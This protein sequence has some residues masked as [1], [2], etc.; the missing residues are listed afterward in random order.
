MKKITRFVS[1]G[2]CMAMLLCLFPTNFAKAA[3]AD[4]TAEQW[5]PMEISLTSTV[6]YSNP[7]K[8]VDI[9][10]VFTYEDGTTISIPGFWNGENEWKVRFSPTKIGNWTF[11]ITCTD[12]ANVSLTKTGTLSAVANTGTTDV[13]K[14]GFVRLE[15]GKR[16]FVYDD[17][18]PFYW[19]GDTH[20]Q[21]PNYERLTECNYPGCNCGSQFAHLLKNRLEKGF[22]VYQTYPDSGMSDGGGNK[23]RYSWWTKK[24]L[25]KPESFNENFDVMMSQLAEVGMTVAMGLGVHSSTIGALTEE[26]LLAYTRYVVARYAC[27]NVV[28]ITGQEITIDKS[29]DPEGYETWKKVAALIDQLDGYKHPQG[30]HMYPLLYEDVVDLDAQPWHEWWTLQAGHGGIAGIKDQT[31]YKSYYD[32]PTQKLYMETEA[33]YED[34]YCGGFT[35]YTAS[36]I[37]AW[38]ANQ[39]G[40]YGFTYGDE[41]IWAMRWDTSASG[42]TTYNSEPWYAGMDKPGSYEMT[43]LKK[44][45]QYVGFYNLTPRFN[46]PAYGTFT[47][48]ERSVISTDGNSTYVV[49]FYSATNLTGKLSGLDTTQN[50]SARWYNPRTGKF[51]VIAHQFKAEADG[52]YTIP[53]KPTSSD[54]TLLVTNKDLGAYETELAPVDYAA[55]DAAVQ[56]D[57]ALLEVKSYQNIINSEDHAIELAFDKDAST[58]WE[59]FASRVSN[60]IIMDLG[61]SKTIGFMKL[62]YPKLGSIAPQSYR[63]DVSENGTDWYIV[64]DRTTNKRSARIPAGQEYPVVNED[65]NVQG[66]YV[67]LIVIG[68]D[69][70]TE[71]PL[72]GEIELYAGDASLLP[73]ASPVPTATP[74]VK[75]KTSAIP[76]PIIVAG[77]VALCLLSFGAAFMF[78]KKKNKK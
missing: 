20:W 73:T 38:K 77:L 44:F 13:D 75:D 32:S 35:G 46:D 53:T 30:A 78:A 65:F 25:I 42:W 68:S 6:T 55:A 17:G 72:L 70:D 15:T 62:V 21:M 39:C 18:T 10:A 52:T 67:R 4:Y 63:I 40:S 41:G 28:W 51:L 49:Y 11:S 45:Y 76:I 54:W 16:Y 26:N 23:K 3:A 74:V 8:D 31:F 48:K 7:F 60:T 34:I 33:N 29:G 47:D 64:V 69:S 59:A 56:P 66:R 22:T 58:Y 50:Y 9:N 36:R 12:S 43:Y 37:C 27:Y 19:L 24:G 2:L 14:K 57:G 61:E 71:K 1:V 5:K